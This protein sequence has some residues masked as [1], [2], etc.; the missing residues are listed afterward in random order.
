MLI[1]HTIGDLELKDGRGDLKKL[2]DFPLLD[3]E[4]QFMGRLYIVDNMSLT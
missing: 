1:D 2:I 3:Y 4:Y